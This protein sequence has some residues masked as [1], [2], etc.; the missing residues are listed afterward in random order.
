VFDFY[1]NFAC[2]YLIYGLFSRISFILK[3]QL[4]NIEYWSKNKYFSYK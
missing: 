2:L 1:F 3:I 4:I